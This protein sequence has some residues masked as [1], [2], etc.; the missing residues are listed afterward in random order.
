MR[1][2]VIRVRDK[3][4]SKN[5]RPARTS[6]RNLEKL[7]IIRTV[8]GAHE[9]KDTKEVCMYRLCL[10]QVEMREAPSRQY[11]VMWGSFGLGLIVAG[12][13]YSATKY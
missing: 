11:S 7:E 6:T 10:K 12:W 4:K 3:N 1:V 5:E 9:A 2:A 8:A 13:G